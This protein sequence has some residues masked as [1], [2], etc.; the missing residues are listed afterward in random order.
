MFQPDGIPLR[1]TV[2][3]DGGWQL[4]LSFAPGRSADSQGRNLPAHE[5]VHVVQNRV[6][7]QARHLVP[8]GR[9]G[10]PPPSAHFLPE[11]D[12]EV[13]VSFQCAVPRSTALHF[14]PKEFTLRKSNP[15]PGRGAGRGD[16]GM[17]REGSYRLV[18]RKKGTVPLMLGLVA[19]GDRELTQ[20][21]Q[22]FRIG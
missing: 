10:S 3:L 2:S 17:V 18:V 19:A 12:D 20:G 16:V 11:V 4:E 21:T 7:I 15:M 6:Q 5:L 8:A 13:L 14:N 9:R 1:A 22:A